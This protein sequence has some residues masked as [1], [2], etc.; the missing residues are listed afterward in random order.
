M[1][2]SLDE[3]VKALYKVIHENYLK[4]TLW[5]SF[6]KPTK[7]A[8]VKWKRS[9]VPSVLALL[10]MQK[11]K[12]LTERDGIIRQNVSAFVSMKSCWHIAV[13]SMWC[14]RNGRIKLKN[15]LSFRLENALRRPQN[16]SIDAEVSICPP[17]NK[18]RE[19]VSSQNTSQN[20]EKAFDRKIGIPWLL[21]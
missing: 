14:S 18:A 13:A 2:I 3:C 11:F 17:V 8:I 9:K 1:P 15:Y 7:I 6:V 4:I 5:N 16:R 21:S 20:C 19:E 12:L 10:P